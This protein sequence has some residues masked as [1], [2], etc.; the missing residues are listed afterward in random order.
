MQ[1][2]SDT[3]TV[4]PKK[5]KP[6]VCRRDNEAGIS[7]SPCTMQYYFLFSVSQSF[8]WKPPLCRREFNIKNIKT[9]LKIKRRIPKHKQVYKM[10]NWCVMC[11]EL[12]LA[13]AHGK[14]RMAT[15]KT[16]KMWEMS[17]LRNVLEQWSVCVAVTSNKRFALQETH[18]NAHLRTT[19]AV[20]NASCTWNCWLHYRHS[21]S[22]YLMMILCLIFVSIM[23]RQTEFKLHFDIVCMWIWRGLNEKRTTGKSITSQWDCDVQFSFRFKTLS[24][25]TF[26]FNIGFSFIHLHFSIRS[27]F[28]T[29]NHNIVVR[30]WLAH[31]NMRKTHKHDRPLSEFASEFVTHPATKCR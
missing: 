21:Y 5:D 12:A 1:K 29:R 31:L 25:F 3:E 26:H 24:I 11:C 14:P 20:A 19:V 6:V 2:W 13:R 16:R 7:V 17:P 22:D 30:L 4:V 28:A 9:K 15:A 27:S 10:R 23:H 8:T 18:R